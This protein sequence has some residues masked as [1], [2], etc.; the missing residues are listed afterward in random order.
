MYNE[1]LWKH[2]STQFVLDGEK[3]SKCLILQTHID[4]L[5]KSSLFRPI[6]CS[7]LEIIEFAYSSTYLNYTFYWCIFNPWFNK[8]SKMRGEIDKIKHCGTHCCVLILPI[9]CCR[10]W[11]KMPLMR[12]WLKTT[13]WPFIHIV[14]GII[15]LNAIVRQKTNHFPQMERENLG[16]AWHFKML[17]Q[18]N[19]G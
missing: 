7:I 6:W 9:L 4:G 8:Y 10:W 15:F 13:Q 19:Q 5:K 12:A 18:C 3:Y 2:I 14:Y 16:T 1:W 11:W 17:Q